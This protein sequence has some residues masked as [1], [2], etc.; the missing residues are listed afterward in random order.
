MALH[1]GIQSAVFY[2]LSCAPCTEART[3]RKRRQEADI[4]RQEKDALAAQDQ[5]NGLS[6]YVHPLPSTTNPAW[7]L[8][9][10][11]GPS[12]ESKA[13]ARQC[14]SR[15]KEAPPRSSGSTSKSDRKD[16]KG[17]STPDLSVDE[18]VQW[19]ESFQR[20][21]RL[22][23]PTKA[24]TFPQDR[25]RSNLSPL[26][27][28]RDEL[29]EKPATP[30]SPQHS[31]SHTA[32]TSASASVNL[33]RP[34]PTRLAT[35]SL[36]SPAWPYQP[37]PPINDFHPATVTKY[38]SAVDVAWMLA[39]PPSAKVMRGHKPERP[40]HLSPR[41]P[42]PA[43]ARQ[44]RPLERLP[45]IEAEVI[46]SADISPSDMR[47]LGIGFESEATEE[48]ESITGIDER[49]MEKRDSAGPQPGRDEGGK[50][51]FPP[52]EWGLGFG[53]DRRDSGSEEGW[54]DH[55][56]GMGEKGIEAV[57]YERRWRWS[58]S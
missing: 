14:K 6:Q 43:M 21:Y 33:Q 1:R 24:S 54:P 58:I 5:A 15:Q 20:N 13:A 37:H 7:D 46:R 48:V 30:T 53:E 38:D 2:Y 40:H 28:S 27:E 32:S 52:R 29:N 18:R 26:S 4:L 3:R 12:K 10:T 17:R 45:S 47:G 11:I 16:L 41:K 57:G 49:A 39:P 8:E 51:L 55:T 35:T 34:A 42:T 25:P 56:S 50:F 36:S 19:A 23:R 31:S 22:K 9:I 44:S